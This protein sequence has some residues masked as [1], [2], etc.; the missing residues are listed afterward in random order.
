MRPGN[1]QGIDGYWFKRS[2]GDT[3][4]PKEKPFKALHPDI[5]QYSKLHLDPAA[6]TG[7]LR[8]K[9]VAEQIYTFDLF[10][11]EFCK[12][13]IEEAEYQGGWETG[14]DDEG[15]LSG[16]GMMKVDPSLFESLKTENEKDTTLSL[17]I[18]P[19]SGKY[20]LTKTIEETNKKVVAPVINK[21]WKSFKVE[22]FDQPYL[23]KY[24]PDK[25]NKMNLHYDFETVAMI[26]YL[27]TGYEGGGTYFPRWD[28]RMQ[29]NKPGQA[30]MWPGGV[31]HEHIGLPTTKGVRYLLCCAFF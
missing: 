15:G 26:V 1:L 30:A 22:R 25:V 17:A 29:P 21:I 5:Y 11:P 14:I 7:K 18:F 13:L 16:F 10:T 31:S 23:L 27:N 8:V 20:N 9:E 4:N 19:S 24:E 3:A 6:R 12:K 28:F 2:L